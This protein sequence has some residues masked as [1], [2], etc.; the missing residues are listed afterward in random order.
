MAVRLTSPQCTSF[1]NLQRLNT[2]A[3]MAMRVIVHN[4]ETA[5]RALSARINLLQ[6]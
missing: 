1:D 4:P 6:D 2:A 5:G 3:V